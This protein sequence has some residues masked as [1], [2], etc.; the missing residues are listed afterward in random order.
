MAPNLPT[1][2]VVGAGVDPVRHLTIEAIEV[3]GECKEIWTNVPIDVFRRLPEA[4]RLAV[5]SLRPFYKDTQARRQN[6]ADVTQHILARAGELGVVGYLTQGHPIIFDSVASNLYR[7][8]ATRS[9]KVNLIN[10]VS[11]IDTVLLDVHFDPGGG[12]QIFEATHF[13][14]DKLKFDTRAALLLLQP[15]VFGMSTPRLSANAPPSNLKTL[16]DALLA[17]YPADHSAVFVRSATSFN[18]PFMVSVEIGALDT[19]A[20][21]ATLAST[22]FIAP[23]R[24]RPAVVEPDRPPTLEP[25]R[26]HHDRLPQT[27]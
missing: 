16:R 15:S 5:R 9:M 3:L 23:L 25:V 26:E 6:Y 14:R 8:G 18:P 1:I 22:L 17:H 7:I 13:V 21:S 10:G 12:L 20:P 27:V 4:L 2:Y 11:C 24:E 19:V